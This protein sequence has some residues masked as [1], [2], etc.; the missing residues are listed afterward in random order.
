MMV[1][2]RLLYTHF[3][4]YDKQRKISHITFVQYVSSLLLSFAVDVVQY[5]R[6]M[7]VSFL[8]FLAAE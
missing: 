5:I 3:L 1:L 7:V 2:G 4:P 8:F 6:L